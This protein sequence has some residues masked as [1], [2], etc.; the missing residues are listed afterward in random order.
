VPLLLLGIA[1]PVE[2][3]GQYEDED[4]DEDEED[5]EEDEVEGEDDAPMD[6]I[7]FCIMACGGCENVF[8]GF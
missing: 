3:E 7:E 5:E 4:E 2:V 1:G 8:G 6:D